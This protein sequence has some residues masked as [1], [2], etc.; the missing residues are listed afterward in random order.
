MGRLRRIYGDRGMYFVTA[1]TFQARMLLTP[2]AGIN[3]I[4]GGVLAQAAKLSGIQLHGFV[5]ASNHVHL[6]V[7][8]E[9]ASLSSFMQ[10]FLGNVARKVGRLTNWSGSLWQRRFSAEAVL[11]DEAS[12]GRLEYIIAHGVKEG[13]VRNPADWPGLSCL[14]LLL[15][16]GAE[17]QRVFRWSRRWKNGVLVAGGEH[18]LDERWAEDVSLE[19]TPLPCWAGLSPRQRRSQVEH[20][21]AR[22]VEAGREAHQTVLGAEMVKRQDPHRRPERPKKSPRPWCH[23]STSRGR[24]EYRASVSAWMA[25]FADA[26]ARFRK[27]EW[28]VLFPPWAFRPSVGGLSS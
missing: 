6:L 28:G 7:S 4:I 8:A 14:H 5:V 27:G 10:Y 25:A 16:G 15:R 1:R 17:T 24:R 18:L 11:D 3:E 26:S 2:G 9:G 12:I 13:L 23:S 21:L 22:V 19:L 20:M